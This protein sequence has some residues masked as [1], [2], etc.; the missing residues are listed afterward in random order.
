MGPKDIAT[1]RA[2]H[3]ERISRFGEESTEAL[4]WKNTDAQSE[5]FREIAQIGNLNRRTLLDV[6]CGHGDFYGSVKDNY[7]ELLYT[8]LDQEDAFLKIAVTRYG[9]DP[10]TKF[11]RGDFQSCL[12]PMSD[13]VICCGGLNYRT[14]KPDNIYQMINKLFDSCRVGLG[15]NILKNVDFED[16]ILMP[17]S[18]SKIFDFCRTLTSKI[19]MKDNQ[20]KNNFTVFVY[21]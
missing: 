21:R 14:S 1:V 15:L 3:S 19:D 18:S 4:G 16:G 8:G 5:R 2:Y 7:P 13:Y 17:Y 9:K 20:N 6:G 10:N 12:L 11:L